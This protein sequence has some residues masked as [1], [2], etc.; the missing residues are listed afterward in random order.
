MIP[1]FIWFAS[2]VSCLVALMSFGVARW[3]WPKG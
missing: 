3:L 2:L 1:D